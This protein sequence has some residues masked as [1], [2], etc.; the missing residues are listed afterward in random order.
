[1][2]TSSRSSTLGTP[3]G[4]NRLRKWKPWRAIPISVTPMNTVAASAKVTTIWLVK[5]KL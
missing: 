4:T 5:V 2:G 3:C 1:M